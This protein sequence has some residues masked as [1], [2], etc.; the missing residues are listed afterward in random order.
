MHAHDDGA[1]TRLGEH[2]SPIDLPATPS[3][4]PAGQKV[5]PRYHD[6][7]E[8]LI[9]RGHTIERRFDPGSELE[10][11]DRL[12]SLDQLHVYTPSEHL[13][14]HQR[15]PVEL[16]LV[17]RAKDGR[18][19]VVGVLFEVGAANGGIEQNLADAP[20]DLGQMDLDRRLDIGLLFPEDK[21][22]YSADQ[23]AHH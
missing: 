20:R 5:E 10:F 16:H 4:H 9:N 21:D 2:Q 18:L 12:Y 19:L 14:E 3:A 22:F 6:T 11:D 7:A 13:I 8:H 1:P 17:H 23:R 15:F